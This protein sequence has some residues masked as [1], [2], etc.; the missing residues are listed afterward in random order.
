[1]SQLTIIV[2]GKETNV[3][4]G[5]VLDDLVKSFGLNL[6]RLAVELN[7]R[8]VH[9]ADWHSTRIT[10]GDKVEIVHFVGGGSDT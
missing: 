8:I 5:S 9:R 7:K 6:E 4:D 10:D 1:M 3:T 2:N